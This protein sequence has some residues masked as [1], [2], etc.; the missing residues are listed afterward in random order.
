MA[1]SDF[2]LLSTV[3]L[4]GCSAKL[5]P[6][7]LGE[8][9]AKL[10]VVSHPNLLVGIE[11]HDDAGV[12]QLNEETALIFTTDFFPPV[13]SSGYEFGQI[14]AANAL[15]DVYAMGGTPLLVLNLSLI[16]I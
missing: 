13:C 15:S 11:T 9:L 4:G 3:E 16:H 8:I 2:D 6:V 5:S 7:Q 1:M 12:Y 14:A 10:P